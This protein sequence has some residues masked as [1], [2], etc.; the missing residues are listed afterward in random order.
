MAKAT[1]D[2]APNV[3]DR[4]V[5]TTGDLTANGGSVRWAAATWLRLP[6]GPAPQNPVGL[7]ATCLEKKRLS[8]PVDV[9]DLGYQVARA[10]QRFDLMLPEARSLDVDEIVA[11]QQEVPNECSLY[12]R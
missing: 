12:D 1:E 8:R 9:H 5:H 7:N 6:T 3:L 11:I 4:S 10:I 2:P